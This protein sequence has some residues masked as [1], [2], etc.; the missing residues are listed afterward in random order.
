MYTFLS[1]RHHYNFSMCA[2]LFN[3]CA[4]EDVED[5]ILQTVEPSCIPQLSPD[6]PTCLPYLIQLT[7]WKVPQALTALGSHPLYTGNGA[8]GRQSTSLWSERLKR[9]GRVFAGPSSP[10]AWSRFLLFIFPCHG[11]RFNILEIFFFPVLQPLDL[12]ML[13]DGSFCF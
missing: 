11:R 9:R 7:P 8:G 6:A 12:Y 4:Q 10:M 5:I 2:S 13:W 3:S 1:K